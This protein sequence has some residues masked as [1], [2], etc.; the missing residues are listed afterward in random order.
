LLQGPHLLH[1]LLLYHCCLAE[2]LPAL[3]DG[4]VAV[5]GAASCGWA[6]HLLLLLL[7]LYLCHLL[8]LL[9]QPLL[10][11]LLLVDLAHHCLLLLLLCCL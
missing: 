2:Q 7:D 3:G 8:L 1:L 5:E 10:L 4:V 11:L 9:L 6:L